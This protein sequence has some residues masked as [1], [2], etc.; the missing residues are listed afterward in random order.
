MT[1]E[2]YIERP[3]IRVTPDGRVDTDNA[4]V[5]LGVTKKTM[6]NWRSRGVGPRWRKVG[7]FVFYELRA[8]QA[9]AA[10]EAA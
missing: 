9:F 8:L 6:A 7:S 5:F 3:R 1:V 4:A 2:P 10:G